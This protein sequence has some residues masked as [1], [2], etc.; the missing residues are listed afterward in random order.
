MT[1]PELSDDEIS[2]LTEE[3]PPVGGS[4]NRLYAAVLI[5]LALIVTI[6]YAFRKAFE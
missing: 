1:R 4:W 3:P 2:R 5:N 6:L